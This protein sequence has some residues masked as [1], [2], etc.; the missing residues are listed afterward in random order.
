MSLGVQE[1]D[2]SFS[3]TSNVAV[4]TTSTTHGK[5]KSPVH[6]HCRTATTEEKEEKPGPQWMWCKYCMDPSYSAQ[7]TTNM[8]NHLARTHGITSSKLSAVIRTKGHDTV[9]S[10]YTQLLLLLGES[11]ETLDQE[12]LQRTVNQQVVNQTL[13]D[14]IIVRRLPFRCVQ[15]PEWHAFVKAL[16]PQGQVFMPTSHTTVQSRLDKWFLQSKDIVR[17]RLQSS[18]THIHLAIDIW[19]SPSHD[20][21]LAVCASFIDTLDSYRNILLALRT[22]PG[23][24]GES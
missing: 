6:E 13:L 15:W 3:V 2:T 22:V 8:R 7:S 21:L 19:T 14:L 16:N 4:S 10:L 9:D 5:K 18:Q 12:I 17:K 11:K 20:L 23:H 24:S 1:S